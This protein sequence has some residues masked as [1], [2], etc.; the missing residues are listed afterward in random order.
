MTSKISGSMMSIAKET[1]RN[2]TI[3]HTTPMDN[4]IVILDTNVLESIVQAEAPVCPWP[5]LCIVNLVY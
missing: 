1:K 4:M 5:L 3:A 2:F